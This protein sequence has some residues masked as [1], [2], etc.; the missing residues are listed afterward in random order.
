[1]QQKITESELVESFNLKKLQ[2]I[3][4]SILKSVVAVCGK[5]QIKYFLIGGTLLGAVRH[6]GFIPWDDD[7]DIGMFRDDYEKFIKLWP[8][9][10]RPDLVLQSKETDERV[11]LSFTK[12]R[13]KGTEIIE[14]ETEHSEIFKG[15]FIDIFPIDNIPEKATITTE[16][17][18]LIFQFMMAI[19][20]YKS[21]YRL[22]R[23]KLLKSICWFSSF[24]P[25]TT[26]NKISRKIITRYRNVPTSHVTSYSSG[27]GYK[28]QTMEKE[29]YGNGLFLPF[30]GNLF[31]VPT[32]HS[33]Y[34]KT[35]FG[36]YMTL[37]PLEDRG[38]R[39]NIISISLGQH[40]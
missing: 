13:M 31:R 18:Y 4:L 15:I 30:E 35:L 37:P 25:F 1:M 38:G 14:K 2:S 12:I 16:L 24:V 34:L 26:V 22:Y 33:D 11:H 3:E 23:S 29:I 17:L 10:M 6:A 27:Y 9:V 7:I 39:H 20:L 21:G 8:Q 28:K 36:D 5:Y 32:R 40:G 19:S